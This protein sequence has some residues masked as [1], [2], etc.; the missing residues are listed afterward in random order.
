MSTTRSH[1][2][3]LLTEAG[4]REAPAPSPEFVSGLEA[5][6]LAD[7]RPATARVVT[8]MPARSRLR[9]FAPSLVAAAAAV[10]AVVLVGGLTGWF[11]QN[12]ATIS[13]PVLV[14]AKDTTV[15]LP[16][17]TEIEG[18]KGLDLPDGTVVRTGPDGSASIGNVDLGPL[19]VAVVDEGRI[20][21]TL[22][23][24]LPQVTTPT[25]PSVLP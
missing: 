5:R 3:A 7:A 12:D 11:G 14:S 18:T 20:E 9:T 2:E 17:G 16:D 23:E 6:L 19:Q 13:E 22:P 15:E 25:T 1:L 21:I 4:A 8:P 24:P 10:A